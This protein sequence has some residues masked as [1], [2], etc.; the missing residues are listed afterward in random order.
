MTTGLKPV[1]SNEESMCPNRKSVKSSKYRFLFPDNL[2][3]VAK[4]DMM[5]S[6]ETNED[7][8]RFGNGGTN[9]TS[10]DIL[11]F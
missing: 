6:F 4:K 8:A 7:R 1:A 11:E 5:P 10:G 3:E 2:T 9:G